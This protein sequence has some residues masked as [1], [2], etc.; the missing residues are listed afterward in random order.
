MHIR[1]AMLRAFERW[2]LDG[3][4]EP[5]SFWRLLPEYAKYSRL[6]READTA[7]QVLKAWVRADSIEARPQQDTGVKSLLVAFV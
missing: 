5:A 4:S 1:A 3:L 2:R 7:H 6:M